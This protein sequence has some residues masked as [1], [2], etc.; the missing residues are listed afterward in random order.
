MSPGILF[1][2]IFRWWGA[3]Q[4]TKAGDVDAFVSKLSPA[5]NALVYS[6]YLGGSGDDDGEGIAV[7]ASGA[8]YI[9]GYTGSTNFPVQGALQGS[10]AG[11]WDAFI[12][13]ISYGSSLPL[14]LLLL[15]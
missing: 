1:L 7:D 13:K 10:N 4:S 12:V 11:L 9:A 15:E 5:G 14:P 6:T 8:A 3:L 2:M